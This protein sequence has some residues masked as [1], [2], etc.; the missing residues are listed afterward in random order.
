MALQQ[1]IVASLTLVGDGAATAFT[2]SI[3]KLPGLSVGSFAVGN[4]LTLPTTVT[5]DGTNSDVPGS[6]SI[7]G[8]GNLIITLNSALANGAVANITVDLLY[9]SGTLQ[10]T[11]AAWTSATALNTTW[12]LPLNGSNSCSVGF[13]MSGTVSTGTILFEVSQD[14]AAWLPIQGAIA[15]GY[16]NLTG[17]TPG[18]G[19]RAL[20]FDVAGY[21]Y[22]RL[23]LN[24][25]ITGTGTVTFIF[26]ATNYVTEPV[27]TVGQSNGSFLHTTLDDAAGGN[28]VN[29]VAK[30]TQGARALTTQD[31]KD[32]GRSYVSFT[33]LAAAGVT[34]EAL[35]SFAQNKQGVNTAGVTSYTITSGKTLRITS[36]GVS[37]RSGAAAVAFSRLALR[38]NTAGATTTASPI[39]YLVPEANTLNA[40]SGSG[41]DV[42]V[43]IPDGIEF[44]GNGTQ[45]IGVSHLDQATTNILNV[46]VYGY[47]Y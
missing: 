3:S 34:A 11:T 33:A 6:A 12:T 21:A 13:V 9:N 43:D 27:P 31:M 46:T 40:T 1:K 20:Q 18:V 23:R 7:D 32:S 16:T 25:V 30:A 24:P 37:V 28:A 8:F 42:I 44:F 19:S 15:D 45:S 4:L 41:G 2:Y 22:L 36:I 47:E 10:G 5:Y 29:T 26:Q 38:H 39:A 14:G 35:L 17:W